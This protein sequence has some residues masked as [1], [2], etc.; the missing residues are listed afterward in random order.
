MIKPTFDGKELNITALDGFT[1]FGG[2]DFDITSKDI[3][4]SNGSIFLKKIQ[5]KGNSSPF[6]RRI[7]LCC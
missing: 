3:A 6:F 2:A 1:L 7:Q 5:T 4:S